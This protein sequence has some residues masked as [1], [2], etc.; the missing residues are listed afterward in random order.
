MPC[1]GAEARP[2][3]G[4]RPPQ[5]LDDRVSAAREAHL[6]RR[7][8]AGDASDPF[9]E[10]ERRQ[11]RR[12]EQQPR[13]PA[14]HAA[15]VHAAQHQQPGSAAAAPLPAMLPT[16]GCIHTD[17]WG[18]GNLRPLRSAPSVRRR[19]FAS[20]RSAG[21]QAGD[22][23]FVVSP[24]SPRS[25]H[26]HHIWSLAQPGRSSQPGRAVWHRAAVARWRLWYAAVWPAAA[27]RPHLAQA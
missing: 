27:V 15:A 8:A 22:V 25:A 21:N 9:A 4:P 23:T 7:R 13:S 12:S 14:A 19:N 2:R 1:P 17:A 5:A 11:A 24:S 16:G 26:D 10:E 6:A 18:R 3:P 20:F